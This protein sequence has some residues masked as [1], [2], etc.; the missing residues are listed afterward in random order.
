MALKESVHKTVYYYLFLLLA[1][2]LPVFERAVPLIIILIVINWLVEGRF[3]LKFNRMYTRKS[4]EILLFGLLFLIYVISLLYTDNLRQGFFE[5][6]VTLSVLVFPVIFASIDRQIFDMERVNNI[7]LAFSAGCLFASLM[8]LGNAAFKYLNSD[9]LN[10]FVYYNL[11][12]G[13]HSSYISMYFSLNIAIITNYLLGRWEFLSFK[14]SSALVILLVYFSVLV[15]L[16]SSKAGILALI[17]VFFVFII[18]SFQHRQ[19][20]V[21]GIILSILAAAFIFSAFY[22]FLPTMARF[23]EAFGSLSNFRN[24][25]PDNTESTAERILIW[26]CAVKAGLEE[27]LTGYGIGDVK[28]ELG[29]MYQKN[30]VEHARRLNLNA[31]NQYLQTFLATGLAGMITLILSLML[32]FIKALSKRNLLYAVFLLLI[33]LNFLFESMLCRQAGVV[34]YAF[35]NGFF[36]LLF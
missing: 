26:D 33:G 36:Y 17:I 20:L 21:P 16:L 6:E 11:A 18:Y 34:F 23:G 27:P 28:E 24:I 30:Q 31:H 2:L 1:F 13:K 5:L 15:L 19:H 32:P 4:S 8:M 12:S 22:L 29:M 25:K 35:F 10:A 3:K 14:I 9:D 7:F